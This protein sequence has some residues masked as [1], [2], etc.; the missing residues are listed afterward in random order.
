MK[1]PRM[2]L[3]LIVFLGAC[4][5][6][7][8]SDDPTASTTAPS[9][10]APSAPVTGTSKA[11]NAEPPH[12]LVA[13]SDDSEPAVRYGVYE[14]KITIPGADTV[15]PTH[16]GDDR[17][18][19]GIWRTEPDPLN[20]YRYDL[21]PFIQPW[22]GETE[23]GFEN[24]LEG[25]FAGNNMSVDH[26]D[27]R[28]LAG[29]VFSPYPVGACAPRS[30]YLLD[31]ETRRVTTAFDGFVY[32][33]NNRGEAVGSSASDPICEPLYGLAFFWNGEKF[34]AI[35]DGTQGSAGLRLRNGVVE[36][37]GSGFYLGDEEYWDT[38]F[39]WDLA[40]GIVTHYLPE[41]PAGPSFAPESRPDPGTLHEQINEADD[42]F[43]RL[44]FTLVRD[45]GPDGC[46]L[47]EGCSIEG[48]GSFLLIPQ[49]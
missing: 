32:D 43:G 20:Q 25:F 29:E 33:V 48:C 15:T 30:S 17:S 16:L 8:E 41:D 44:S 1:L 28:Y 42:W 19:A 37:V 40:T 23:V 7:G 14:I 38:V 45:V 5:G 2:S 3:A 10:P 34:R 27:G 11:S 47:V 26:Y 18:I 36:G 46:I 35:P 39:R 22:G 9:M 31:T 12:A 13:A 4:G 21:A 6:G 24:L 49:G